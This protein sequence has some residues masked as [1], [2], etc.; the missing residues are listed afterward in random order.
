MRYAIYYN[1]CKDGKYDFRTSEI[2]EGAKERD[3]VL[4]IMC[5]DSFY[6]NVTWCKIYKSGEYGI[7]HPVRNCYKTI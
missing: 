3:F 7:E 6:R 1:T 4:K 5:G 2:V